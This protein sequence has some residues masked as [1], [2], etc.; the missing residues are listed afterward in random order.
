MRFDLLR[1]EILLL[2]AVLC[3]VA[4]FVVQSPTQPYRPL[5][6]LTTSPQTFGSSSSPT[7]GSALY[8][9]AGNEDD[10]ENQEGA[11]L[12]AELFKFAQDKGIDVSADDLED[13]EEDDELEDDDDDEEEFNIPQGA[14]NAFLGYDTGDVGEK[15]A[16]NVSLTDD[17]LYSEM[18]DRV[19]DTAGGFVELV[20]G[21]KDDDDDDDDG[22]GSLGFGEDRPRPYAAPETVPDS[23]LTAGE[24]VIQVLDSL[25]HNDVPTPNK[26]VEIFFGYSSPGS[27]VQT[28]KG[29]TPAEYADFLKETEYKVLFEHKGVSIDKADY[30]FDGKKAFFTARLQVGDGPLDTVSVNFILSTTGVDDDACWLIDSMLIRPQSMRRRRRR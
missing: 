25:L 29:L 15:L 19:L 8:S 23:E 30:S 4:S 12:A 13:D 7:S 3:P 24:V 10:P 5:F 6:V 27:Q 2:V 22:E 20:G 26:G 17:Q 1:C 16:G 28:E 18:K 14:I 21:A 11:N 9:A